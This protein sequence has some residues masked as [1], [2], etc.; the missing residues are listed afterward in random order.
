MQTDVR[1]AAET[2]G[3][4]ETRVDF[5]KI[6]AEER[7]RSSEQSAF[8]AF[9]VRVIRGKRPWLKCAG[10]DPSVATLPQDDNGV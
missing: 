8:I 6:C 1:P 3:A 2:T 10:P 7:S 4:S 5:S 9:Q